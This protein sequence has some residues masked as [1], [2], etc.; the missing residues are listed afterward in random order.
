MS[1]SRRNL[2]TATATLGAATVLASLDPTAATAQGD[3]KI[4]HYTADDNGFRVASVIITG[5]REAILVDAQFTLGH[6]HRVVADVLGAGKELTTVYITH[7]HPDHYFGIEVIK[8]AFPQARIV[9][10]P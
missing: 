5:A 4:Q 10:T 1:L 7:A 6:A 2:L 3:L 9:A 8:A